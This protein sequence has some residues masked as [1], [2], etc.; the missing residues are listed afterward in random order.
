MLI[1]ADLAFTTT[2]PSRYMGGILGGGG[3]EQPANYQSGPS[4]NDVVQGGFNFDPQS[5]ACPGNDTIYC[6]ERAHAFAHDGM[7]SSNQSTS[8]SIDHDFNAGIFR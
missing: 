8:N 1:I 5:P 4:D 3:T 7:G 2:I 6:K